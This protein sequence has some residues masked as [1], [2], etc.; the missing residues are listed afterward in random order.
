MMVA[1]IFRLLSSADNVRMKDWSANEGLVD[2][3]VVDLEPVQA[4]HG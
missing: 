3:Q 4:G 1:A 2:L